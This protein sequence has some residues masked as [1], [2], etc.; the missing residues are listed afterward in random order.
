MVLSNITEEDTFEEAVKRFLLR[1]DVCVLPDS[2]EKDALRAKLQKTYGAEFK[3]KYMQGLRPAFWAIAKFIEGHQQKNNAIENLPLMQRLKGHDIPDDQQ[4]GL[5]SA[6]EY[7]NDAVTYIGLH[8]QDHNGEPI[9]L[10]REARLQ[11]E[12]R[13][14]MTVKG[15]PLFKAMRRALTK[16]ITS[17]NPEHA[18]AQD[19]LEY[20]RILER[21]FDDT[22]AP[23]VFNYEKTTA[24]SRE[25]AI[26]LLQIS[27][28]RPNHQNIWV[29]GVTKQPDRPLFFDD[30]R[31]VG[32]VKTIA[33]KMEEGGIM[34]DISSNA[35][36]AKAR[37][38]F[39]GSG[40][41]ALYLDDRSQQPCQDIM[42]HCLF[43]ERKA[44]ENIA[45]MGIERAKARLPTQ[46]RPGAGGA[47]GV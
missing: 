8:K 12:M 39:T 29:T 17:N 25:T 30:G 43:F 7:F 23:Y 24:M 21:H 41:V 37:K 46:A 27:E 32:E 35:S 5:P 44:V 16:I 34:E 9:P 28:F 31:P 47:L 3:E 38:I 19:Y 11:E 40:A 14:V 33:Q 10:I 45:G 36:Q 2:E 6:P 1:A 15:E 22:L 26:R 20:V 18:K 4:D 13:E 42:Y